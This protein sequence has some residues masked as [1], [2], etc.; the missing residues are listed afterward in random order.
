MRTLHACVHAQDDVLLTYLNEE[1]QSIEPEWSVCQPRA[2]QQGGVLRCVARG[3]WRDWQRMHACMGLAGGPGAGLCVEGVLMT[4]TCNRP[5]PA[6]F[7][8]KP[9]PK[10]ST[11]MQAVVK[12]ACSHCPPALPLSLTHPCHPPGPLRLAP[13]AAQVHPHPAHGADQR[14]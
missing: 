13:V 8:S 4:I 10:L 1:G 9:Q 12:F 7:L 6:P 5:V 14:R 11:A 3:A 2:R